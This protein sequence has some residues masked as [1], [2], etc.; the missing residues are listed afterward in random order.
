MLSTE[1]R[2]GGPQGRTRTVG[3]ALVPPASKTV[4]VTDHDQSGIR[5]CAKPNQSPI[6]RRPGK[7]EQHP[8]WGR[9]DR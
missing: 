9:A 1:S 7:E 5:T 4:S 6:R 8:A 2:T 3:S